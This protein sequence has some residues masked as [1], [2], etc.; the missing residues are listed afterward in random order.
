MVVVVAVV[1][2]M[3]VFRFMVGFVVMAVVQ[4]VAYIENNY[5]Y[6]P[7][8]RVNAKNKVFYAVEHVEAGIMRRAVRRTIESAQPKSLILLHDGFWIAPPTTVNTAVRCLQSAISEFDLSLHMRVNT[9]SG[10]YDTLLH[11]LHQKLMIT[12]LGI[13]WRR[14]RLSCKA[15]KCCMRITSI[16]EEDVGDADFLKK[17]MQKWNQLSVQQQLFYGAD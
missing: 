8:Y 3:A 14:K 10:Q 13:K 15:L 11:T 9:L 16:V 6:Q 1:V 2:I 17:K 4:V 12:T 5:D 7:D